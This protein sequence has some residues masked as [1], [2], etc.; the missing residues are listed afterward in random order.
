[1]SLFLRY[2]I[3]SG[4]YLESMT[5]VAV[6][7]HGEKGN[8]EGD[9]FFR[10]LYAPETTTLY[11]L[12]IAKSPRRDLTEGLVGIFKEKSGLAKASI[13]TDPDLN[14]AISHMILNGLL[15]RQHRL[16]DIET[17]VAENSIF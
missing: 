6:V 2:E 1:M 4:H 5:P 14:K 9:A 8:I 11:L 12:M 7:A 16:Q 13:I 15:F 17:V 10:V 3:Y